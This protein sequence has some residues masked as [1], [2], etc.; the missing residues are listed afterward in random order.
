MQQEKYG[1]I[2]IW[3]D[4]KNTRF[5]IGSHWGHEN[6]GYICSSRMMRQA[7]NRRPEDFK[8]RIIS[9]IYSNRED[10]LLE[11]ERWLKMID[12]NKTTPRNTTVDSRQSV[13]YYNINLGTQSRWWSS[14]SNRM[15][16]GQK[17]SAVKSGKKT[18]PCSPEKAKAISEAKKA[19]FVR[20]QE[21]LG[22]KMSPEHIAKMAATKT[23]KP[24]SPESNAKRSATIQSLIASGIKLG[25]QGP[26][27]N[28]TKRKIGNAH[29]GMKRTKE[30]CKNIAQSVSKAYIIKYTDGSQETVIGLKAYAS[31]RGLP[32]GSIT[33]A[34]RDNIPMRKY[35]IA[36]INHA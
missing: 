23:G 16:I 12:P 27:S 6:D 2:Y 9:R 33:S 22:Y 13:R 3:F 17:I 19:S 36:S 10:L 34:L 20:K 31:E 30:T 26:L 7:Y 14:D 18:G 24:Q 8:R 4:K 28:E 29:R 32:Y 5:Y 35:G 21:I 25:T 15:T 1:F 11:E